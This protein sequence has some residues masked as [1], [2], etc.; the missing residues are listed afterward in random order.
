MFAFMVTSVQ[1]LNALPPPETQKWID[2]STSW[3][4]N[5]SGIP[6]GAPYG[7]GSGD[8]VIDGNP[9]TYWDP[10]YKPAKFVHWLQLNLRQP[11]PLDAISLENLGDTEHDV[12]EFE[13]KTSSDRL[14][15]CRQPHRPSYRN[16]G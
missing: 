15:I 7:G 9:G 4:V 1:V 6:C 8:K 12:T 2:K 3:F 10:C 11:Y 5:A 14:D 13:L 16:S